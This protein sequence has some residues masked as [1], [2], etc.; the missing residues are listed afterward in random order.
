MLVAY[1][2]ILLFASNLNGFQ[3]KIMG[4]VVGDI[5]EWYRILWFNT[6][7]IWAE[8]L[9]EF[10]KLIVA[11]LICVEFGKNGEFQSEIPIYWVKPARN[12][13]RGMLN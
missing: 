3:K 11:E 12:L 1:I 8:Y 9:C 4:L 7:L 10:G 5:V 6:K 2:F 13:E